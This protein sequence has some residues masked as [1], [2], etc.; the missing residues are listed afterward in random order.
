M[1]PV[2]R[3]T[4]AGAPDEPTDIDAGPSDRFGILVAQR[5]DEHPPRASG[6]PV[7]SADT[8]TQSDPAAELA[9]RLVWNSFD[10]LNREPG[11]YRDPMKNLEDFNF[12]YSNS[13]PRVQEAMLKNTD[14]QKLLSMAA[15][16]IFVERNQRQVAN[17]SRT[18]M[19]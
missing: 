18:S 10:W 13:S 11:S 7:K 19:K 8:P 6:A 15:K 14:A 2:I 4:T 9:A 12:H 1:A 5:A 17:H 16:Q 3:K